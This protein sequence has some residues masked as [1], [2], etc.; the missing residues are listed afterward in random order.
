[1]VSNSIHEKRHAL[2]IAVG[3]FVLMMI[4]LQEGS[5]SA[6]PSEQWNKTF[7]GTSNY[8]AFSVQQTLDGGYIIAGYDRPSKNSGDAWLMKTDAN[9]NKQWSKTFGDKTFGRGEGYDKPLYYEATSVRQTSDGGYIFTG[10]SIYSGGNSIAWLIKTDTNGN[11]QWSKTFGMKHAYSIQQTLDGEYILAGNAPS[12]TGMSSAWLIKTDANGN[13]VWERTFGGK[14]D[15]A[16]A[17]QQ[18]LDGGYIFAGYTWSYGFGYGDDVLLIKTDVNGNEMWHKTLGGKVGGIAYSVQQTSDD[19]Y[20]LA[21]VT[22]NTSYRRGDD[23]WLVK[24]DAN[25]NKQWSK[26]FGDNLDDWAFSVQQTL[27][28]GYIL[29]GKKGMRLSGEDGS[30]AWLVKTD[31]SGNE[32]WNKTIKGKNITMAGAV[33][34]TLARSVQQ[35]SDGSYIVLGDT[36][37]DGMLNVWLVKISSEISDTQ[38]L[39]STININPTATQITTPA[40]IPTSQLK[41]EVEELKSNRT[42]EKQ[43]KQETRISWLEST[44]NSLLGWI[45]SFFI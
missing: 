11:Q 2:R 18:T 16:H 1:M 17:V 13:T 8:G 24:T 30:D 22:S 12:D 42:A 21:G 34:Q 27:D 44:I 20:I 5:V 3:I 29:A 33:H 14:N 15:G 25:G 7:G 19:G 4:L 40:S 35:T 10:N 26:T 39:T 36:S 32:M 31:A 28:G 9:G 6:I 37:S 23:F 41:Q 38:T 45:K 43:N